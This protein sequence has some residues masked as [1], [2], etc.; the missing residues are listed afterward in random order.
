VWLMGWWTY[1]ILGLG[2][3]GGP[4]CLFVLGRAC[5]FSLVG[6]AQE[7]ISTEKKAGGKC[8]A[9]GGD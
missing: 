5:S 2:W 4:R 3:D 6:E 8:T 7:G 1:I 9:L